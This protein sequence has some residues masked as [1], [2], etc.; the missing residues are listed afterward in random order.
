MSRAPDRTALGVFAKPVWRPTLAAVAFAGLWITAILSRFGWETHGVRLRLSEALAVAIVLVAAFALRRRLVFWPAIL[1][2]LAYV[3]VETFSTLLNRADWG[4]GL[5]LDLLLAI[6]ALIAIG[7][8]YLVNLIDARTVARV[9]VGV[10]VVESLAAIGISALFLVH[11]TDFGVQI[12][13]STFQCKVY[14]TMYEA[15]LLASYLGAVLVFLFATRRLIGPNWVQ[16]GAAATITVAIGLTLTRAAWLA[17]LA[18]VVTLLG[19]RVIRRTPTQLGEVIS[20]VVLLGL[21]AGAAV[22]VITAANAGICGHPNVPWSQG[23]SITGRFA[24]QAIALDE[25]KTSPLVGLGTGSVRGR[26]PGDPNLPWISS[27]ALETLHDTGL[28]GLIVVIVLIAALLRGLIIRRDLSD[29]RLAVRDGIAAAIIVLL[30]AFQATTGTLME[31]PWLFAG[32]ALGLVFASR[33][34]LAE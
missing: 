19:L 27:M 15:N 31:Y 9:I 11:A 12:D 24:N 20:G 30:I 25:W 18:G 17:I 16:A 7:A 5:K 13:G 8:A 23:A 3:A 33:R 4:R 34:P 26:Q 10:G 28:I 21:L 1:L 14:G 2:P 22:V 32:T 29:G 6:E